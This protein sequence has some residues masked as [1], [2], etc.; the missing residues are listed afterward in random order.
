M[1]STTHRDEK[2]A[3]AKFIVDTFDGL[4][5]LVDPHNVAAAAAARGDELLGEQVAKPASGLDRPR[6]APER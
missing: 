2:L 5:A 3:D 4:A 1:T 6:P